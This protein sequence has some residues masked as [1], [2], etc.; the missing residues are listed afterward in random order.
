MGGWLSG[1]DQ[2]IALS[3]LY[4]VAASALALLI[5]VLTVLAQALKVARAEPAAALRYE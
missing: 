3:P 5:A 2:R 1:F 4:F